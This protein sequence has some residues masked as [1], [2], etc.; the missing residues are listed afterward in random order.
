MSRRLD[1]TRL[2]V[3]YQEVEMSH[4][5]LGLSRSEISSHEV[6]LGKSPATLTGIEAVQKRAFLVR[7]VSQEHRYYHHLCEGGCV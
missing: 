5:H 1:Q 2:R 7:Y 4:W 6:S 3:L